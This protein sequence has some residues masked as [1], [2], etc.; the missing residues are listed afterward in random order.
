MEKRNLYT[1]IF[2]KDWQDFDS[3]MQ[4][5]Y[6]KGAAMK[7]PFIVLLILAAMLIGLSFIFTVLAPG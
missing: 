1:N 5:N 2:S 6:E 7:I 3:G 4:R